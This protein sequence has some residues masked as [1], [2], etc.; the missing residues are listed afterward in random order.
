MSAFTRGK[1]DLKPLKNTS[2][3]TAQEARLRNHLKKSEKAIAKA[4]EFAELHSEFAQN[5]ANGSVELDKD[6]HFKYI[7]QKDILK[8]ADILTKNKR[9]TLNNLPGKYNVRYSPTGKYLMLASNN[10]HFSTIEWQTKQLV[11]EFDVHEKVN[12]VCWLHQEQFFAAAQSKW[13]RIYENDTG[14]EI[15][16]VNQFHKIRHLDFLPFHFLLVGAAERHK[17]HYLDISTGKPVATINTDTN[18]RI[19]CM[20]QNKANAIMHLAMQDGTVQLFS[21]NIPNNK[22]PL[23]KFLALREPCNS[24]AITRCGKYLAAAGVGRKLNIFDLRNS[25]KPLFSHSM[26]PGNTNLEFSDT[27]ILAASYG[28]NFVNTFKD[29]TTKYNP[30]VYIN[31]KA[32]DNVQ[33]LSFC[34]NED[35][36]GVGYSRGFDSILVPGSGNARVDS[37]ESNPFRNKKQRDFWEVARLLDKIPSS[38]ICLD[39]NEL[40]RVKYLKEMNF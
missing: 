24:I 3:N 19:N 11:Q 35:V 4:G 38:M 27:N 37:Y 23:L 13:T 16:C 32:P 10:G 15:H 31:F 7:S 39:N 40:K 5:S 18:T 28:N 14:A 25:Y 29:M 26:Y 34:P 12:D 17:V 21:P 9:F 30:G 20:K 1:I 22:G 2:S 33:S 6:E 36:L 8:D